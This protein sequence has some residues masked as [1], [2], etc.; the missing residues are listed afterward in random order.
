[1]GCPI[2][3]TIPGNV[4]RFSEI[5]VLK[6]SA[7]IPSRHS[8]FGLSSTNASALLVGSA[9]AP[10]SPRPTRVTIDFTSGKA[11]RSLFSIRVVVL[12]ASVKEIDGAIVTRNKISPSSRAGVNSDPNRE[13]ASPPMKRRRTASPIAANLRRT[14]KEAALLT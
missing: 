13:P 1:M 12:E 7:D 5:A 9:C 14:K 6:S 2:F 3:T 10:T 8:D 4:S 11:S